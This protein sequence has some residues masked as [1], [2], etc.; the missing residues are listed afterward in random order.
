M[1][2]TSVSCP[3]QR[4]SSKPKVFHFTFLGKN[5]IDPIW[6]YAIL[7]PF[8]QSGRFMLQDYDFYNPWDGEGDGSQHRKGLHG[9]P[10]SGLDLIL[11]SD[12]LLFCW[13]RVSPHIPKLLP[14]TLC[15]PGWSWTCDLL[16]SVSHLCNYKHVPP[17]P[18]MTVFILSFLLPFILVVQM[19][20]TFL[21]N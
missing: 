2:I 10:S 7:G 19:L 5:S 16:D 3:L 11:S 9:P 17:C 18:V 4:K 21:P 12:I 6:W 20:I 14:N 1:T 8:G 15:S 13:H